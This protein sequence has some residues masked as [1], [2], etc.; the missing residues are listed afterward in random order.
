MTTKDPLPLSQSEAVFL[1]T[2]TSHRNFSMYYRIFGAAS[3]SSALLPPD[4]LLDQEQPL[5]IKAN[6]PDARIIGNQPSVNDPHT[7]ATDRSTMDKIL[8]FASCVVGIV[9]YAEDKMVLGLNWA[10]NRFDLSLLRGC[11]S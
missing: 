9:K 11:M 3:P 10:H 2:R 1:K 5:P 6:G 4:V 8:S 7:V